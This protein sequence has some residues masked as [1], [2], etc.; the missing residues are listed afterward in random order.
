MKQFVLV[1]Y[2]IS[3]DRRRLKVMKLLEGYGDH[4]QF[5]VFEC[6]LE[7]GDLDTL[8]R[9]LKKLA[10]RQDSVRLYYLGQNDVGRIEII[11]TG[12]VLPERGVFLF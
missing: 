10:G 8:R 3:S 5:S 1:S 6:R 2:D 11:G 9:K 4:V 7:P 12:M